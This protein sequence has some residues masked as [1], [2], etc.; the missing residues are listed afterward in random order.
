MSFLSLI[1]VKRSSHNL[2]STLVLDG[3]SECLLFSGYD[4]TKAVL[5]ELARRGEATSTWLAVHPR[6]VRRDWIV[7]FPAALFNPDGFF[8]KTKGGFFLIF[9]GFWWC[10]QK[11]STNTSSDSI[12][13]TFS[14]F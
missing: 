12:W 13:K 6:F 8:N 4:L 7:S 3:A 9:R 14:E 2:R 10:R 11:N 1:G 5:I